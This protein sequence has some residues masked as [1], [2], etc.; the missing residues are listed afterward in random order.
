V[1][2]LTLVRGAGELLITLGLVALL[3]V[4][5]Q[6]WW[7]DV[8]ANRAVMAQTQRLLDQFAHTPPGAGQGQP[9]APGQAFAL[10]YIPALGQNWSRPVIQGVT[11]TDLAEGVGHYPSSA[12][13]GEVGNFA[14]AGHR[15][16]NGEP[17]AY[18]DRVGRGDDVI[19]HTEQAWFVYRVT[20]VQIVAPTDVGVIAP[21]PGQ[22]DA[23]PR[24]RLITLTTCSPRWASY[25]RLILHGVL[26]RT[27]APGHP[28]ADLAQA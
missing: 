15:A 3:F 13:P 28:P 24:Q 25:A 1:K 4:A 22:P 8:M 10:M 16:T 2:P 19:V 26:V 6:L 5:Y 14:V 21:V 7:T 12:M 18:L 20:D 11:L 23:V 17:F 9:A 27:S